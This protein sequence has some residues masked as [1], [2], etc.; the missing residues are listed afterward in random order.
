MKMFSTLAMVAALGMT[1]V[2]GAAFADVVDE[3]VKGFKAHGDNLKAVKAAVDSGNASAAV[4]PAK[5]MVVFAKSIP[6]RFP[7]GSGTGDT[8]ALPA[9][10]SDWAGFEK[11]A[12][13]HLAAVQK[14][15]AVAEAGDAAALGEQLKATGATCGAC[16]KAY[17]AEK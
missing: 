14:L 13:D 17:R 15:E 2:A 8:R 11:A 4:E 10:W 9:I 12:A 5:A 6:S 7:E 16:H 1:M 3:R